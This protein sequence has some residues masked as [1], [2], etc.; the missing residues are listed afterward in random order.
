[1]SS[2]LQA[3]LPVENEIVIEKLVFSYPGGEKLFDQFTEHIPSEKITG[4]VGESGRGK[5]TLIDLIA[6][7]QK[8]VSGIIYVDGKILD[9]TLQPAW[10]KSIGYLPQDSFFIE[11][12]LRE[13]LIWDS[14]Q[15]IT[16]EKIWEVLSMVNA[17]HL[18]K[19]F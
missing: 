5:T 12:T 17:V 1:S 9:E 3:M 8:P 11:G 14:R 10:K 18:V 15:K 19:R 2:K 6:G 16:D 4:I 13:N 7:L